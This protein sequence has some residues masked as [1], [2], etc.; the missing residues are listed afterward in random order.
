MQRDGVEM[1]CAYLEH[2]NA[3]LLVDPVLPHAGDDLERFGRAI[4][5][6]L[7]RLA[8][9]VWVM[10]TR[11]DRP[12]D[13]DALVGMTGGRAWVPGDPPPTGIV[14]LPTGREG[15]A[16]LWSSVHRALMPGTALRVDAGRLVAEPG[17]DAGPLVAMS[18][19]VVL[20]SIGPITA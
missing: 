17:V 8:G 15:E 2:G 14:E 6:D 16:A 10:L 19:R 1:A 11:A 3:M 12:R 4:E 5:R 20:P 18:A 13:A 9:P 7:A